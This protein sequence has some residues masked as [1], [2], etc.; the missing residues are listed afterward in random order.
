MNKQT[1]F[2]CASTRN[3]LNTSFVHRYGNGEDEWSWDIGMAK[4]ARV[5]LEHLGDRSDQL[6]LDVG[7]GGA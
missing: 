7:S 1:Q 6:I 4:A 2:R 5:F 3:V